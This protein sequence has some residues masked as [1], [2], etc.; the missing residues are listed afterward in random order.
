MLAYALTH[1]WQYKETGSNR[2]TYLACPVFLSSLL[3]LISFPFGGFLYSE[4]LKM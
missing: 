3:S 1:R 2:T 4:S